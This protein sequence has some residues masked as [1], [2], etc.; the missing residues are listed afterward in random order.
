MGSQL[1]G[2]LLDNNVGRIGL[3]FSASSELETIYLFFIVKLV[4]VATSIEGE[5]F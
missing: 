2:P 4:Y 3:N 5:I 1:L